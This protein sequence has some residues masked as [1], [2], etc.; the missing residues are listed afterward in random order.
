MEKNRLMVMLI[1]ITLFF[2]VM[3]LYATS[4]LNFNLG[5]MIK[6]L[7]ERQVRLAAPA[8]VAKPAAVQR[9]SVS[10][11]DDAIKGAKNAPV[12]IVEFTDYQCPFSARFFNDTLPQLKK[13]YIESGKARLVFRDFP[14]GF[15]QQAIKVAE[16]AECAGE[17]GKYWEYH[18]RIFKDP[19][20]LDIK[21]LKKMAKEIGLDS[22]RFNACLDSGEMAGEVKKDMQDGERYGVR[23]TPSFFINGIIVRG[24]QPYE[25]FEKV[26]E[27]ELK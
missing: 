20:S 11:D 18:D 5:K 12:T 10:I 19:K 7:G 9:I 4:I 8:Q 2:S 15:H 23:G 14:L 24:S 16:A 13:K 22:A 27:A 21:R 17:Q 26:I 1:I 25:E 3:N 6:L